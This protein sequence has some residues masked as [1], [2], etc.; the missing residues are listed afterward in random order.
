MPTND[1]PYIR[2][3]GEILGSSSDYIRQ[4]TERA[5]RDRAPYTA[6]Y[7]TTST[8][9]RTFDSSAPT[10]HWQTFTDIANP[11]V[12]EQVRQLVDKMNRGER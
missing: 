8:D 2:A 4:Q 6:T 11:H 7:Y 5:R 10:H 3:W 12:R 1:Y 9:N